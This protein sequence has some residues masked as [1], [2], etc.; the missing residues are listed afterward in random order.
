MSGGGY[1][2]NIDVLVPWLRAKKALTGVT[3]SCLRA[4]Q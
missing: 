3:N 1:M 4:E 2:S